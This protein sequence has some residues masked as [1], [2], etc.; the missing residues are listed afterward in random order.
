MYIFLVLNQAHLALLGS[1][2]QLSTKNMASLVL[3]YVHGAHGM[4]K[5]CRIGRH[6]IETS[7]LFRAALKSVHLCCARRLNVCSSSSCA[8]PDRTQ[9][10][11]R[12]RT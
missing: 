7:A 6:K 8:G 5:S 3:A 11:A 10:A 1:G 2:R 4:A 12:T 9:C